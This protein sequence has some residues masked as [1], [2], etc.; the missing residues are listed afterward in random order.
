MGINIILYDLLPD[1]KAIEQTWFDF[2]RHQWDKEF[3]SESQLE[4][5]YKPYGDERDGERYQRPKDIT[6]ARAWVT[7]HVTAEGNAK[8]LNDLLDYFEKNPN[9]YLYVSW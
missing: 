7:E 9:G 8:R 5:D 6:A 3:V 1:G 4:W 2:I